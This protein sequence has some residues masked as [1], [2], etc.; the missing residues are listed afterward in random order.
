MLSYMHS[1]KNFHFIPP[2][3]LS[4]ISD[5]VL[6]LDSLCRCTVNCHLGLQ[7]RQSFKHL[8]FFPPC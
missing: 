2:L 3:E 4:I 7:I 6:V 8:Y 1:A 5:A